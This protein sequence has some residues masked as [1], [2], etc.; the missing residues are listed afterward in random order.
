METVKNDCDVAI[1]GGGPAGSATALYLRRRGYDVCLFEKK[2]FPRETVC[3]EFLSNEVTESLTE[4][5]L[6]DE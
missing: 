1:V 6:M 5:G 2:G 4:L 3:G